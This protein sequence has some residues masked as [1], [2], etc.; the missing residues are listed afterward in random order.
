MRQ[1]VRTWVEIAWLS[2]FWSLQTRLPGREEPD[3]TGIDRVL[4]GT[5]V[6]LVDR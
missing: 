4:A 3:Q 2:C 5:Y 1:K 6:R